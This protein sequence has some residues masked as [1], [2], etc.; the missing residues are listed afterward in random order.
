MKLFLG[1]AAGLVVAFLCVWL[2]EA[3]GHSIFPL[4]TGT[5]VTDPAD[6]ARLMETMPFA[7]KAVVLIAWFVAALAGGWV[8]NRIAERALPGWI[9]AILIIA[10]GVATMVMI[11]H[12]AWMWAGGIILPLLG[13]WLAQ[14]LTRL[15]I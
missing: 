10:A 13:A 9:V 15:P 11:P 7:A 2:I 3:L 12:P 6:Q 8:G 5:D 1:G 4:P 14:R